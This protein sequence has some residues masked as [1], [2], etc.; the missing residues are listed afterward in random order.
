MTKWVYVQAEAENNIKE[1]EYVE[2]SATLPL[3]SIPLYPSPLPPDSH[4]PL[5][6]PRCPQSV[7][8]THPSVCG[9]VGFADFELPAA[10]LDSTL[11]RLAA[12]PHM[13]GV[14][15]LL[16]HHPDKP[17]ISNPT[18]ILSSPQF[19]AN[20]PLL[21]KHKLHFEFHGY[22]NQLMAG[23]LLAG[24]HPEVP[25]VINHSGLC[26]DHTEEGIEQ[27]KAGLQAFA[28]LPHVSIKISG[29]GM[30]DNRWTAES[31]RPFILDIIAIFGVDR[32]MFASN[33]PVEKVVG[34]YSDWYTAF[35]QIVAN[36]PV[37]QQKK[38]FYDNAIKY[39][40]L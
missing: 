37:E 18:D 35:K 13:K 14:R 5:F 1:A 12:F 15:Q 27:W 32:C 31:I 3:T 30:T 9:I 16:N 21:A 29:L 6:P 2:V 23:A 25:V 7:I 20:Y 40:R 28:A 17:H 36:L 24:R 19:S 38:L 4:L 39:Y 10:E 8:A 33:F 11:G 34:A 22:S 26:V